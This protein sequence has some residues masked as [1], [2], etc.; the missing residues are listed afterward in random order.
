MNNRKTFAITACL[1]VILILAACAPQTAGAD[2]Y[3]YAAGQA[4]APEEMLMEMPAAAPTMLPARQDMSAAQGKDLPD[5]AVYAF[6]QPQPPETGSADTLPDLDARRAAARMIIKNAEVKLLVANTD[7]AID[8]VTQIVGDVGG[9]I[10]S[11][12]VWYQPYYEENYKYATI[13]MG[14]PVDQ[15]ETA[16]RRLRSLA[17]QVVDET[18]SG[19]DVTDQFVDLQSQVQNL[20]ATRDRIRGFL[21]QAK[22]VDEALR[23]N[24]QLSDVERQIEEIKGRM[25]YLTDRSA[26]STITVTLEPELPEIT[27]TPTAT[28][29]PTPTPKPWDPGETIDRSRETL[30]K[31]YQGLAEFFI[32]LAMVFIPIFGPWIFLAWLIWRLLRRKLNKPAPPPQS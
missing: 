10:I 28:P 1:L 8:G 19:E 18:A 6:A 2:E 20:E 22:T 7:I 14:V 26:Y 29:L 24:Q 32:W 13:T 31:S 27:P 17:V 30:T 23:I 21:D 25:N 5:N 12:R 3:G 16:M 11:S 4:G 15:F 9:Y